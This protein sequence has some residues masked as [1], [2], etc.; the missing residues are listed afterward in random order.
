MADSLSLLTAQISF[1]VSLYLVTFLHLNVMPVRD[2]VLDCTLLLTTD[3]T[4]YRL[5]L[6]VLPANNGSHDSEPS[7]RSHSHSHTLVLVLL[8]ADATTTVRRRSS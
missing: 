1:L 6:L 2:H 8:A 5:C 4:S 3:Q 7:P